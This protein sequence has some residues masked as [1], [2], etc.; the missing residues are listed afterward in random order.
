MAWFLKKTCVCPVLNKKMKRTCLDMYTNSASPLWDEGQ[1]KFSLSWGWKM[2][3]SKQQ[4]S[5]GVARGGSFKS[6]SMS[7][8]DIILLGSEN[9]SG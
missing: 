7:D 6:Q 9:S 2:P 1:S 5:T 8:F 3:K 4:R